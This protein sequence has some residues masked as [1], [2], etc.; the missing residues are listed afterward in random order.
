MSCEFHAHIT[1]FAQ[2]FLTEEQKVTDTPYLIPISGRCPGCKQELLWG[3]L[4]RQRRYALEED[5]CSEATGSGTEE[6]LMSVGDE[7]TDE[8]Q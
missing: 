4:I 6:D 5:T 8:F 3:D 2:H 1:C 7:D